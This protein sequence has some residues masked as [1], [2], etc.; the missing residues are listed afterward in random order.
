M[1]PTAPSPNLLAQIVEGT[2]TILAEMPLLRLLP[3]QTRSRKSK[4]TQLGDAARIYEDVVRFDVSVH[5][6]GAVNEI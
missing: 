6:A 5:Q 2:A 3:P 4:I 1:A